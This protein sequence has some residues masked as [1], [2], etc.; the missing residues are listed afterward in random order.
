MSKIALP[1]FVPHSQSIAY[2]D[3]QG[4][5]FDVLRL[6]FL[7]E[8]SKIGGRQL[9]KQLTETLLRAGVILTIT[10]WE[11]FVEGIITEQFDIKHDEAFE[12]YHMENA[13][14]F[15]AELWLKAKRTPADLAEWTG[16]GWKDFVAEQFHKEING[17]NTPSSN[18]IRTLSRIY[19]GKDM[20]AF[21]SWKGMLPA[22]AC[23]KLDEFIK[24]R[25]RLVHTGRDVSV[26]RAMVTANQFDSALALIVKLA[27]KTY[28]GF[29]RP[30][31]L[32]KKNR[33]AP[34]GRKVGNVGP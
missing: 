8:E 29:Y 31:P 32:P 26:K 28:A 27:N 34:I 13:F 6:R 23:H 7:Y 10:A 25:G 21:W 4:G 12:T 17:L 14:N 24:L 1:S 20:T 18:N 19:L 16:Y 30:T 22:R 2:L 33:V 5:L 11:V 3:F 9:E 15:A